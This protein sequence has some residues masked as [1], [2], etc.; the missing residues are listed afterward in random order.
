MQI[1]IANYRN[2]GQLGITIEDGKVNYL[3]GVCGSGK[4]SILD[5]IS[6]PVE[7]RDTTVGREP[8]STVVTVDGEAPS[9]ED[10][11]I[12]SIERQEVLFAA[13]AN[14]DSYRV[15][16][17]K[18]TDLRE[19]EAAF[20]SS[21]QSLR[22]MKDRLVVF[23][24]NIDDLGK[25]LGKPGQSGK[26]TRAA[27][28]VKAHNALTT[29]PKRARRTLEM[30]DF[31]YL[32]WQR[33]G[34]T[35]SDA[36]DNG[37][38]PFCGQ[39]IP[40]D[41]DI[42]LKEI[43]DL[44]L[45]ELKPIFTAS[46]L[47]E[48][49]GFKEPDFASEESFTELKEKLER[50][51]KARTEIDRVIQYCNI[52]RGTE[53]LE[54]VPQGI[55][56]DPVAYEFIPELQIL[57]DDVNARRNELSRLMGQMRADLKKMVDSN[58]KNINSKLHML[59]IPYA[60]ELGTADRDER[61]ASYV[62]RHVKAAQREDM[63]ERLSYGEKNLI[64][65]LLFLH[66]N[67]SKLTLI[68]DPASSYDDFRRSQIYR[69][70]MEHKGK[71]VLVVSHDQAFVRRAVCERGNDKLGTVTFLENAGNGCRVLPITKDGF[72]F[73]DDEIRKRIASANGYYQKMVNV[74]L[75][76]DIHRHDISESAWGYTS[77]ILHGKSRDCVQEQLAQRGT[78]E[79]EVLGELKRA[80]GTEV[81]KMPGT[82]P[83]TVDEAYTDYELLIVARERLA[84]EKEQGSLSDEGALQLNM[85][86]DLVHMNDCA[87]FCLNPYVYATWPA[88]FADLLNEIRA[89]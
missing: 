64:A 7:P 13:N 11:S 71:T 69:C 1:S 21:I 22:D 79:Q 89:A 9:T 12:Y 34:F 35:I 70:I 29:A 83:Q 41:R 25:Q 42:E 78:N 31:A 82:V 36:F 77:A 54:G 72:V 51:F 56:I 33:N 74:R 32:E 52:G 14:E 84:K 10:A 44:T 45:K 59:G 30:H 85:L 38:C 43:R 3:F 75:F 37:R 53:L 17:G 60:F 57:V 86:N 62:L 23:R 48:E 55:E 15:F 87:L 61:K 68:D 46:T 16:I 65:L 49:L 19:H 63:R 18:E 39:T 27:K 76:C 5:A 50:I 4:S 80:I 24:G 67:E 2:I 47:M 20:L 88:V 28:V 66:N 40:E 8:D 81:E 26:Y 6:K 73:I 58:A